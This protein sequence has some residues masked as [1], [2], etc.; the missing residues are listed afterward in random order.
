MN[1]QLRTSYLQLKQDHHLLKQRL[2]R[3]KLNTLSPYLINKL[4]NHGNGIWWCTIIPFLF[5]SGRQI[6]ELRTFARIFRDALP[7]V[8]PHYMVPSLSTPTLQDAV[9][10][11]SQGASPAPEIWLTAGCHDIGTVHIANKTVVIRG[12]AR[13]ETVIM[14]C[15]AIS[16]GSV[17]LSN[18]TFEKSSGEE[19]SY[20]S[21]IDVTNGSSLR[22]D[23]VEVC[24]APAKGISISASR[25]E[26][27]NCHVHNNEEAGIVCMDGSHVNLV[28]LKSSNNYID[29]YDLMDDNNIT[30]F[31]TKKTNSRAT[32]DGYD[33]LGIQIES[34]S[35]VHF[36]GSDTCVQD[37]VARPL[38]QI[39]DVDDFDSI[40]TLELSP[41]TVFWTDMELTNLGVFLPGSVTTHFGEKY[42]SLFLQQIDEYVA[43]G[44]ILC[45]TPNYEKYSLYGCPPSPV[46]ID[47]TNV[48]RLISRR[49]T[50]DVR[51][52]KNQILHVPSD[53]FR[54]LTMALEYVEN[55]FPDRNSCEI[56]LKAGVYTEDIHIDDF[57]SSIKIVG[58]GSSQTILCGNILF[59]YEKK[60]GDVERYQQ[61]KKSMENIRAIGLNN[62]LNGSLSYED[63]NNEAWNDCTIGTVSMSHLSIKPN[64][65][66]NPNFNGI[67]NLFSNVTNCVGPNLY[68]DDVCLDG[69]SLRINDANLTM[70]NSS[71][72]S[73]KREIGLELPL[74]PG[75]SQQVQQIL[76]F[77][78]KRCLDMGHG[79][80]VENAD[81]LLSNCKIIHNDGCGIFAKGD[82]NIQITGSQ[83]EIENNWQQVHVDFV[84][85]ENISRSG[86]T[87]LLCASNM[88]QV[89]QGTDWRQLKCALDQFTVDI[90]NNLLRKMQSERWI[91]QYIETDI[92]ISNNKMEQIQSVYTINHTRMSNEKKIEELQYH[93]KSATNARRG[94]NTTAAKRHFKI[95]KKL[96]AMLPGYIVEAH[97]TIESTTRAAVEILRHQKCLEQSI[98]NYFKTIGM[99]IADGNEPHQ[100]NVFFRKIVDKVEKRNAKRQFTMENVKQNVKQV[101]QIAA[102]ER[103][104]QMLYE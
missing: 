62:I 99:K 3:T 71:I 22:C 75:R 52:Q 6:Q 21:R 4:I 38:E 83:S 25:A 40:Y 103:R 24:F 49:E 56:H 17:N 5:G 100:G 23:N 39:E 10:K 12:K 57:M 68:F 65:S 66:G 61:M 8:H 53:D 94:H 95:Y 33:C 31:Q 32:M 98:V 104:L 102:L 82:T 47:T 35:N 27:K 58:Q 96:L 77:N 43:K 20:S 92:D 16:G 87:T 48:R 7:I 45:L 59:G 76:E 69:I 93:K 36:Y 84:A 86:G 63:L 85:C 54:T 90:K 44:H 67:N 78:E 1:L 91:L 37:W 79:L 2:A 46:V 81:V 89:L 50:L 88:K 30:N 14:G 60:Y 19:Q 74:P 15:L 80:I 70:V 9:D 51:I 55:H 41:T 11:I 97:K 29:G 101:T 18:L 73:V 64:P 28:N 34:G 26:L 42:T 72:H 13:R